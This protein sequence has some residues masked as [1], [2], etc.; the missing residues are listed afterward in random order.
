[1]TSFK[2]GPGELASLA[3]IPDP[4]SADTEAEETGGVPVI[5]GPSGTGVAGTG[6]NNVWD[7]FHRTILS[8]KRNVTEIVAR[9]REDLA[10]ALH[11]TKHT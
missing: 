2:H 4:L 10:R 11:A 7:V 3:T 8:P 6:V 5:A 9:F 1:M